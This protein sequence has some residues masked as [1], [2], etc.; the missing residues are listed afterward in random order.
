[1]RLTR[2]LQM[3]QMLQILCMIIAFLSLFIFMPGGLH[4]GE[5]AKSDKEPTRHDKVYHFQHRLLPK[6][7]HNSNGEF[8]NDLMNDQHET[9]INTAKKVVGEEFSKKISLR[10]YVASNGVLILF[11]TPKETNEC[12]FIFIARVGNKFIFYTYEK[13]LDLFGSGIKGA[14]CE[15]SADKEHRNYG[16]RKYVDAASFVADIQKME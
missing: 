13:A 7:T 9:I 6:W 5:K 16:F 11:P 10:K 3:L 4:A 8:F 14:V 15:W 2:L 1:M 12:Y